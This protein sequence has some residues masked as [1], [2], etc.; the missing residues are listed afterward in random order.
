M[1]TYLGTIELFPYSFIP[2][3]WKHCNGEILQINQYQALYAIIG[4]TYGGDGVNT[5]ALPN[6]IGY[7]PIGGLRYCIAV[8][9]LFPQKI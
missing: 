2:R 3:D 7:E 1:D 6:F 4:K 8:Y 9:G 5:F